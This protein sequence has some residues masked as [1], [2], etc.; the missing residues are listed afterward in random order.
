MQFIFCQHNNGILV[1]S[2]ITTLM[3]YLKYRRN[4]WNEQKID[5]TFLSKQIVGVIIWSAKNLFMSF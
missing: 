2:K 1:I 4:F 3:K 5:E